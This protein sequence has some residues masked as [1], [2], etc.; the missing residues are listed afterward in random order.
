ME[1]KDRGEAGVEGRYSRGKIKLLVGRKRMLLY[2][3]ITHAVTGDG[4]RF[5][6]KLDSDLSPRGDGDCEL[7]L[8]GGDPPPGDRDLRDPR[9]L[10]GGEKRIGR[11]VLLAARGG[12]DVLPRISTPPSEGDGCRR[13]S[14][15]DSSLFSSISYSSSLAVFASMS[16]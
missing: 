11:T 13:S 7:R 2:D 3:V 16:S 9:G 14:R 10:E 12:V 6:I 4:S 5:S 8:P 15:R 1:N